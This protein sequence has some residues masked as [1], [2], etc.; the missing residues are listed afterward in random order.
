MFKCAAFENGLGAALV[1]VVFIGCTDGARTKPE[2][3]SRLSETKAEIKSTDE[4]ESTRIAIDEVASRTGDEPNLL[5][6]TGTKDAD[7]WLVIVRPKSSQVPGRFW[8]VSVDGKGKVTDFSG[9]E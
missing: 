9:G 1:M 5:E 7:G 8:Y 3:R 4:R 2:E 6:A